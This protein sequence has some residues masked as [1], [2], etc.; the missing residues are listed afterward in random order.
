RVAP[1][2]ELL[3]ID[4]LDAEVVQALLGVLADV[5]G[6]IGLLHRVFGAGGPLP[7][8]W[9][10]LRRD[11]ELGV[12]VRAQ[13]LAEEP[14]AVTGSVHPRGIEERAAQRDCAVER[15]ER[16]L[17][18]GSGPSPH[19]PHPVSDLGNPPTRSAQSAV[20]HLPIL[21]SHS[22]SGWAPDGWSW[23]SFPDQKS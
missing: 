11:H 20:A 18:V 10:N 6:W 19:A 2:V 21:Q 22:A 16:F 15:A 17:V 23:A 13:G 9:R 3:K 5:I 12:P 7:V 4:R 14:L 1:H 8:H